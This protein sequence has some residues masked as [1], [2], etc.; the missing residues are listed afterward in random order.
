[1]KQEVVK[2][3]ICRGPFAPWDLNEHGECIACEEEPPKLGW[4][5]ESDT[6]KVVPGSA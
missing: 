4:E 2:C 6:T 3:N 1:M 5:N